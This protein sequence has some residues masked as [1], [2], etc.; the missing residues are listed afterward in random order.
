M[1]STEGVGFIVE[2]VSSHRVDIGFAVGL[3]GFQVPGALCRQD[4]VLG[5]GE[6]LFSVGVLLLDHLGDIAKIN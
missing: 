6:L 2:A 3:V 5:F 4:V 1:G